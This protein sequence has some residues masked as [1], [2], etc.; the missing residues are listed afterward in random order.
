MMNLPYGEL[1][2]GQRARSRG[3]TI[4]ETDVV[5]FCM[6]TGNWLE[7]HAN[8][9]FS[10]KSMYRQRVVQGGLVFVISNALLGFDSEVVEAFYGVDKLRFLKPTFIGDTL[11]A[12][13]EVI[14]LRDKGENHG[15]ATALLTAVNQR[16]ERVMSCEFSLLLRR[17]RLIVSPQE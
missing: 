2:I 4:T 13:S 15:V 3:R 11:Y 9:E 12:E 8:A 17:E 5:N 1:V 16:H 7:I 6:L 10:S 14:A